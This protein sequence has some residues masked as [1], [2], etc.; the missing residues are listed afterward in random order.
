MAKLRGKRRNSLI[1]GRVLVYGIDCLPETIEFVTI[2]SYI[3]EVMIP[4]LI[5]K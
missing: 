4:R 1:F 5:N 2:F 3:Y